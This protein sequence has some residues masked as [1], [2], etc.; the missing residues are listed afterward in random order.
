MRQNMS[1]EF[2]GLQ[3]LVDKQLDGRAVRLLEA[4]CGSASHIHFGSDIWIT[5]IDISQKQLDRHLSLNEKILGDIQRYDLAPRSF[6]A[7]ICWDVLEHLQ[8][9]N[10]ALRKF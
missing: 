1:F 6:D 9:P 2:P 4:G 3:D 7:I 8:Q 5:G 10:L